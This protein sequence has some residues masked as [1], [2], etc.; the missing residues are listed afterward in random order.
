MSTGVG[1]IL[2]FCFV[3]S[4]QNALFFLLHSLISA[5]AYL[6]V[7]APVIAEAV[8]LVGHLMKEHLASTEMA[9]LHVLEALDPKLNITQLLMDSLRHLDSSHHLYFLSF[10][11][12][13]TKTAFVSVQVE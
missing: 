6:F 2:F 1:D 12:Y 10:N 3:L 7:K 9:A 8:H 13:V 5:V 11:W 4:Y